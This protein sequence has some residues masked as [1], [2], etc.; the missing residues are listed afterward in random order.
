MTWK[1]DGGET[2]AAKLKE[3]AVA[4]VPDSRA[5]SSNTSKAMRGI[6][7]LVEVVSGVCANDNEPLTVQALGETCARLVGLGIGF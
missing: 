3:L 4:Q 1:L 2:A 5:A 6:L 7:G